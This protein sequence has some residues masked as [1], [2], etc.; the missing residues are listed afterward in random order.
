[1]SI[2]VFLFI[3]FSLLTVHK[4]IFQLF[5]LFNVLGG[6]WHLSLFFF[7]SISVYFS[8]SHLFSSLSFPLFIFLLETL[9]VTVFSSFLSPSVLLFPSNSHY[10]S[11]FLP[12]PP[13]LFLVSSLPPHAQ[14]CMCSDG[15]MAVSTGQHWGKTVWRQSFVK[16][17]TK[18]WRCRAK[19]LS[20]AH[21]G[22]AT[23]LQD[24]MLCLPPTNHH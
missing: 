20:R 24:L 9:F 3:S 18:A 12:F 10:P 15:L 1:M 5:C 21:T 23:V 11:Y 17:R 14:L 2:I 13:V 8:W 16:P 6:L 4:L 19:P 7:K 22:L